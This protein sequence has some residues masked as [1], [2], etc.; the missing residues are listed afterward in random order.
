MSLYFRIHQ[1]LT[2]VFI[3]STQSL[4]CSLY[5]NFYEGAMPRW[6]NCVIQRG[7][8]SWGL[9]VMQHSW[10]KHFDIYK[11]FKVIGSVS[12]CQ[13]FN[14]NY[15]S[16]CN[17]DMYIC[18]LVIEVSEKPFCCANAAFTLQWIRCDKD[19]MLFL[20]CLLKFIKCPQPWQ[21]LSLLT[22]SGVSDKTINVQLS[23]HIEHLH[24]V[25]MW[26]NY[27]W[28]QI[29]KRISLWILILWDVY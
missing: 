6:L 20:W 22:C 2:S 12:L 8:T 15:L 4:K 5:I 7:H 16:T 26:H 19:V 14:K 3:N 24:I 13:P 1:I 27:L 23:N 10:L 18:S 9:A 29:A 21:H 17:L 28:K 11:I 25:Y